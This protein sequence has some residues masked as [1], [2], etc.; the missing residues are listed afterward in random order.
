MAALG[1]LYGRLLKACGIAAAFVLLAMTALIVTDVALRNLTGIVIRGSVELTEYGLFLAAMLATPWLLREGRHI[2][3]DVVV[4]QVP[5]RIGWVLEVVCDVIGIAL[6]IMLARYAISS[7][8]RSFK[9]ETLIVKDYI[10]PEW[11]VMWPLAFMF[12]LLSVE[13][14]FRIHRLVTG[15][16]RPRV[17]GSSA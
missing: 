1:A 11:W 14:V 10:I 17:E 2:R 15:P 12:V 4:T 13:F 16:R 5:P 6:S 8:F 7:T 3:I 9:A